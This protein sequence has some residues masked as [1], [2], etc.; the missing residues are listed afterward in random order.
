MDGWNG[1]KPA[2]D[3]AAPAEP[4]KTDP[5]PDVASASTP[6]ATYS[7]GFNGRGALY[8]AATTQPQDQDS[9]VQ[10]VATPEQPEVVE[11]QAI[12]PAVKDDEEDGTLG[13]RD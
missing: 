9:G 11:E 12:S 1:K 4:A 6:A 13:W 2:A 8:A 3:A 5:V 7:D 10:A